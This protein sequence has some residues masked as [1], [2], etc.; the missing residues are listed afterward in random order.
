MDSPTHLILATDLKAQLETLKRIA[1]RLDERAEALTGKDII[2]ME[3][4]AYQIHNFYNAVEDLLKLV[5][6][7]FE[8]NISDSGQWHS[9][10]LKRMMQEIPEIR[11]AVLTIETFTALNSLRGFRH[12]FRHA[13]EV[14]INYEQLMVNFNLAKSVLPQLEHDIETFL[15][16]LQT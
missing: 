4:V 5:A 13:Y 12:F 1:K 6:T 10:L 3:S 7:H 11:P 15:D 9:A 16:T 8:N 2:P 14:P